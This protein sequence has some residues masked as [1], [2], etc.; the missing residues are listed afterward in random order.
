MSNE[1]GEI[2]V[3][4][5]VVLREEEDGAF[6]FDPD[7]GRICYLN[8]TGIMIWRLCEKSI[9]QEKLVKELCLEYDDAPEEKV[10]EDCKVFLENL[11]EFGFMVS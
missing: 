11:D 1:K 2:V 5:E 10:S 6:L 8:D 9:T 7:T 3:K 4:K